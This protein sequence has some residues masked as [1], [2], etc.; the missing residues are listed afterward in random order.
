MNAALKIVFK[1]K[2]LAREPPVLFI[3]TVGSLSY[4][5]SSELVVL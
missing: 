2:G 3:K 1:I 5:K 4:L